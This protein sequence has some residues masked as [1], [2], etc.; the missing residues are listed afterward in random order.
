[1]ISVALLD[2]ALELVASTIDHVEI[3]VCEFTPL[4]LNLALQLLPVS[5][6]PIPIHRETSSSRLLKKP[7]AAEL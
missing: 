6:D 3:I 5:F 4:L 1:L 2:F 7:V